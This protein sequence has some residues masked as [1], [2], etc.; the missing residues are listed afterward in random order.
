MLKTPSF[1]Y[2]PFSVRDRMIATS[3]LPLSY[4]YGAAHALHQMTGARCKAPI[5]V[6]CVGNLTAGGSGKTPATIALVGL[7]RENNIAR[8][9]CILTRGYGGTQN[10]PLLVDPHHHRAHQVGDEALLL[11]RHA[12][13]I[14]ARNRRAGVEYAMQS[15]ADMVLMDDGLQNTALEKQIRIIVTDASVGFGNG[16]LLPAGPLRTPL[17]RGFKQA[18]LVLE[19]GGDGTKSY[20]LP[21]IGADI[22]VDGS[23]SLD[24]R[25]I[26]FC[27]LGRPE[28]F[29]V[30]AARHGASIT[31]QKIFPDHHPYSEDD[32]R[33]LSAMARDKNA[34][35][36]TT[37]KDAARLPGDFIARENVQ[38]LPISLI[39]RDPDM[40]AAHM[41]RL[42]RDA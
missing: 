20:P 6:I 39:W 30:T 34:R 7:V 28:K 13:V 5:P 1:W 15:G 36:L 11:A 16:L 42:L 25:Y 33:M 32:L 18:D 31:A 3:L 37:E 38:I 23:V 2:P 8:T 24:E 29:F 14:V 4:L 19:I 17:A 9:P 21:V 10:G 26:A 12:P 41:T 27:G 40:V 35:L 22:M